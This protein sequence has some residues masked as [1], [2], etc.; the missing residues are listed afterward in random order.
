MSIS[1]VEWLS[2]GCGHPVKVCAGQV[3]PTA[4]LFHQPPYIASGLVGCT[5][6]A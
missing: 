2:A 4:S 5:Q 3:P 1:T 6:H